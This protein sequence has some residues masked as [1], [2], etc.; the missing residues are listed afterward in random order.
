MKAFKI[1]GTI[2][3]STIGSTI[4]SIWVI[5]ISWICESIIFNDIKLIRCET[6]RLIGQSFGSFIVFLSYWFVIGVP[7]IAILTKLKK[8]NVKNFIIMGLIGGLIGW[9]CIAG[10]A[11]NLGA[12]DWAW[13]RYGLYF[14][15]YFLL[16]ISVGYLVWWKILIRQTD[17]NVNLILFLKA[18]GI[19]VYLGLFLLFYYAGMSFLGARHASQASA[20]IG[21]L[22]QLDG[23]KEQAALEMNLAE[24]VIVSTDDVDRYIKGGTQFCRCPSDSKITFNTSYSIGCIGSKPLCLRNPASHT[25]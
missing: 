1:L 17:T 14:L 12:I 19:P 7:S 21:N 24:G 16:S 11:I 10:I 3:L 9:L 23:A 2:I 25:L 4:M 22:R 20:C 18:W 6:Y 8:T 15:I 13:S 5:I